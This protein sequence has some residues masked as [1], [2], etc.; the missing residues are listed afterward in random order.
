MCAPV[1]SGRR[2]YAGTYVFDSDFAALKADVPKGD[3]DADGYGLL[4]AEADKDT[5][6]NYALSGSVLSSISSVTASS[7]GP[8]TVLAKAQGVW[9]YQFDA[10]VVQSVAGV[11]ATPAITP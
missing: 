1:A 4:K 5:G 10:T 6:G 7:T 11:Q 8:L 2:Q 9:V 3:F